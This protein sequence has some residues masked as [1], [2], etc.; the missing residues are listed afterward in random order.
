[1]WIAAFIL[2]FVFPIVG[3]PWMLYLLF[4][5]KEEA[6]FQSFKREVNRTLGGEKPDDFSSKKEFEDFVNKLKNQIKGLDK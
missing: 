4:K 6:Q 2:S 5:S 1:M 3:I